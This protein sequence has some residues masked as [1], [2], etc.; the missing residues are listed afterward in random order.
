[1]LLT[2]FESFSFADST[3]KKIH[4]QPKE[5]QKN[6]QKTQKKPKQSLFDRGYKIKYLTWL[7]KLPG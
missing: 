2:W 1:M 3:V 4:F 7:N 6:Q 5:T